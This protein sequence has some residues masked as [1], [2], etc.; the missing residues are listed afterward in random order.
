MPRGATWPAIRA[1][2]ADGEW[3]TSDE[4]AARCGHLVSPTVAANIR[5]RAD[6]RAGPLGDMVEAGRRV[7]IRVHL[8]S[9]SRAGYLERDAGRY[10]SM[11]GINLAAQGQ[12]RGE[13]SVRSKLNDAV[14]REA[15][16]RY[17]AG[18]TSFRRLAAEYGVS[19]SAVR[20]AVRGEAWAHV[21]D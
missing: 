17:R 8:D 20:L 5:L 14:V 18:G 2:L 6:L 11:P 7:G 16:A 15:R 1:V 9:M 19:P 21:R 12:P 3:H 13:M 10:R 4:V